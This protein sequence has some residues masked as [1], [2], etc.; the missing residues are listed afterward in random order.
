MFSSVAKLSSIRWAWVLVPGLVLYFAPIGRLTADQRHLLAF[1]TSTIIALIV[2]PI[3]MSVC[4]LIS[5]TLLALTGTISPTEALSGFGSPTVWLV[6]SAFIYALAVMKTQLGL[7]IA[8][9][10][11][12]RFGKTSLSLGYSLALSN[13]ALAT[14]VPSDTGRGGG[15]MAPLVRN[16]AHVLGSDP[17]PTGPRIGLYLTL[18]A[19]H[20]NY[21]AS[22][23]FLTGMVGN[24]LIAK[25]AHEIAGVDLSWPRWALA[26][27]VPGLC[28]F[29]LVPWLIHH[30][31][32]PQMKETEHAR[33]FAQLKLVEMGRMTRAQGTLLVVLLMVITGW[34]TAPLHGINTTVMALAGLCL[35]LISGVL[36]WDDVIG[37][38][39]AWDAITWF[40]P[41]LMM[42]EQLSKRGVIRIVFGAA[43]DQLQGWPWAFALAALAAS[44]LYAHYGFASMT[45]HVSALYP[46][47]LG[48]ALVAGAPGALAVLI[49]AFFSSL[50]AGITHY[51]TG[52]ALIYFA[53]GYVSQDLWW[54]VGFLVSV[55]NLA[56]W[57]GI[58]P[59]WWDIVGLW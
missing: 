23:M 9:F 17:G 45:A 27:S 28:T 51:G 26:S 16:I 39:K 24:P 48:A 22:A 57:G 11:I 5:M 42:A 31:C 15:I 54:L 20:T 58:G 47:F 34:I 35:L 56:I 6:F 53:P 55:L 30:L 2:R 32:P 18:V 29:A 36:A 1:F 8:Y 44:Y 38:T 40:A 21:A 14:V 50:N 4:V 52:S 46:G 33:S 19:F 13:L 49:L 3:P 59:V 7:R 12:S 25:Y 37:H 10:F 43:F 41:L